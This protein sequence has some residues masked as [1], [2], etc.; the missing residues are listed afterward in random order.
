VR[1]ALRIRSVD[2]LFYGQGCSYSGVHPASHTTRYSQ[3][4]L[5]NRAA[6]HRLVCPRG[7]E[8]AAPAGWAGAHLGRPEE[9]WPDE[10][11]RHAKRACHS[12]PPPPPAPPPPPPPPP[13]LPPPPRSEA[14]NSGA[15]DLT[16]IY[17]ASISGTML[18]TARARCRAV[19]FGLQG[20]PMHLMNSQFAR[21]MCVL[22]RR[23][24]YRVCGAEFGSYQV[25]W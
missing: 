22:R 7:Q 25:V 21:Q 9:S 24:A 6:G 15:A 17:R 16:G 20:V 12:S 14:A 13:P 1:A 11:L 8:T 2:R 4:A 23:Q 19:R 10:L 3:S 5:R 18:L